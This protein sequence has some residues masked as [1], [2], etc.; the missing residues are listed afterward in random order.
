M[1]D[2][3][4]GRWHVIDPMVENQHHDYSPYAYA[5]NNPVLFVDVM[6]LDTNIYVFDQADRPADD[7]TDE[8]TYTADIYVVSDDGTVLGV[9]EGSSYPNST[10][11]S[12]NSTPW[13]TVNEG[14]HDYHNRNGHTPASTGVTEKGLNIDDNIGENNNTS[15]TADGTDPNGNSITMTNVNVHEGTSNNGNASSRGSHGCITIK[16]SDTNGFFSNFDWSGTGG[17][18]GNTSGTITVYRG[19]TAAAAQRTYLDF[20]RNLQSIIPRNTG[21]NVR[22]PFRN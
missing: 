17:V 4:L 16:P 22:V 14:E 1:Y 19:N 6:G 5:Y 21:P 2:P 12:D 9:Y 7:G 11:N 13:N 3:Q 15:R 8:N 18:R 10:S 20:Q